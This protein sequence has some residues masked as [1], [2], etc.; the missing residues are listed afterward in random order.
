[1]KLASIVFIAMVVSSTI[2]VGQLFDDPVPSGSYNDLFDDVLHADSYAPYFQQPTH[3]YDAYYHQQQYPQQQQQQYPQQYLQQ[4]YPQQ[5]QQQPQYEAPSSYALAQLAQAAPSVEVTQGEGFDLY[6]AEFDAYNDSEADAIV[7]TLLHQL[8]LQENVQFTRSIRAPSSSVQPIG[9][10][11]AFGGSLWSF[12]TG[13][14]Y[15]FM[16]IIIINI[17]VNKWEK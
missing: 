14:Q 4:Y 16:M 7:Q 17:C 1:M 9:Q 12:H 6:V 8:E 15:V 3:G 5:Y 11:I 13:V 10:R 2:V